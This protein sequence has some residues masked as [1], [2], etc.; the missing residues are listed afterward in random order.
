MQVGTLQELKDWDFSNIIAEAK[1]RMEVLK[2][3]GR[4]YRET[5]HEERDRDRQIL[6]DID[7]DIDIDIDMYIYIYIY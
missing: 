6:N 7:I 1:E 3:T 4:R 2:P 5:Y